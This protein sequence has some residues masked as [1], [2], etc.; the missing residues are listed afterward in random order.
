[1]KILLTPLMAACIA[2]SLFSCNSGGKET[3]EKKVTDS[4]TTTTTTTTTVSAPAFQPFNLLVVKHKV[5]NFTKWDAVYESKDSLRNAYGIT[6]FHLGRGMD[7]SN[8]VVVI[9]KISDVQKA[10]DFGASPALKAAMKESGV[11]GPPTVSFINIIR[12][13]SAAP[14]QNDRVMVMHKVKDFDAWLK[15]F[16]GEGKATR[17]GYGL[18]DRALGRSLED[19]NMVFIVFTITDM[20]KAKA[21]MNSPELKKLMTDAGVVGPPQMFMY[22]LEY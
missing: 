20:A 8:T 1:M 4:S 11:V 21:R 16:D 3:E 6:K 10:K 18:Q 19:S 14:G 15:V 2:M 13:D 5:A 9:D 12:S 22:K 17:A 7:D